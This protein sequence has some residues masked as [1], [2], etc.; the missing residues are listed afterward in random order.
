VSLL[1][2]I[3]SEFSSFASAPPVHRVQTALAD[4]VH[5]V[6]A[7][8]VEALQGTVTFRVDLSADLPAVVIDRTLFSRAFTN[9]IEN[10]LHAM[11]AGGTLT[12]VARASDAGVAVRISDT[13]VGM[14]AEALARAFEPYFST[15]VTGTGLG[16][17][18][19]KRNVELSGGK[20]EISSVVNQG[21][22]VV[23]T[24]PTT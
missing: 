10:A 1:R 19:A 12:V 7:P 6:V 9:I 23:L 18:I 4:V 16:L 8:Y 14:A 20:V 3:A 2:T 22:N 13:G 5:G 21:T 24:L 17:P 15:K 11:P